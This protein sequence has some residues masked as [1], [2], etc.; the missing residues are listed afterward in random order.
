LKD[1]EAAI[2]KENIEKRK[3][4]L[5]EENFRKYSERKVHKENLNQI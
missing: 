4:L 1:E 5:E 3:N 2:R